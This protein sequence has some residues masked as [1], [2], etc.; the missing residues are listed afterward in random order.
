MKNFAEFHFW[1]NSLFFKVLRLF[2]FSAL[3]FITIY[4][5]FLK[6]YPNIF[7]TFFS[8]DLFV[9]IFFIYK[10]SRL[11][12]SNLVSENSSD[13]LD[14]FTLD[15]FGI[16][17]SQKTSEKIIK[18]LLN[19]P[20]SDFILG[21]AESSKK[22]IQLI[23]LDTKILA[24]NALSLAKELKGK[25]VTTM[26]LF[27]SYLLL[28]EEKTKFLFNKKLKQEDVKNILL[29][30]RDSFP[31]EESPK[32]QDVSFEG[33]GIAEEW[34]YGWTIETKKYM[35]DLSREFLKQRELPLGREKEYSELTEALSKGSSAILVG[36]AGSGKESAVRHLAIQSFMGKLPGNLFHQKIFQLMVDAFMAG[37]Q[38][39][40]ELQERLN[41]IIEEVS[42][43]GN[44][45]IYIPEFQNILGSSS[46][47]L[48][49]SGAIAP[50]VKRGSV[51]IVAAV[52]PGAYKKF[53]EPLHSL[54]D[55]FTVINFSEPSKTEV[56]DML[57]K[58][59]IEI[60]EKNSVLLS[61]KSVVA[62]ST[63]AD[64]YVKEKVLP[65]SAVT[66]LDDTSNAA[67][68]KGKKLVDE[69]DVLDQV[70]K[71]INVSVGEPK[72]LEKTLLL[73]MEKEFHKRII[74]QNEAVSSISESIRRLRA[75]LK[76]V[77]KP[78]SFLFLGPT[79]V[80]KT[81]TAKA[82]ADIYF[83]N[84]ERLVRLDMSEFSGDDGMRRLLGSGPG[85]GDEKG[86]LTEP[87]YDSPYSLI[88]LDEFEKADQKI[89][90][91]FLQVLDDGRLT[92]NKGKTVSFVNTIVIA[93]SN[94]ASEFIRE[95]IGKGVEVDKN[96]KSSLLGF[97]QEKGIFK[98]ELLNRFDDIVVFKP[99]GEEEVEQ[100]V[101]MIIQDVN[102]RLIEKD[103]KA[104][105]DESVF[106]KIA[107][108]GFDKDF[109]ARPLRRFVQ[110]N[111]EGAIAQK[112]LKDEI[113]RGDSISVL[114]DAS[115][116]IVIS[117][118]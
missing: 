105:F 69:Q 61:Y 2:I 115:N 59:S 34:I 80:G 95:E 65:G 50:Y 48:D 117:S 97:L 86:Q 77:N 91:L 16:F 24:E 23:S 27:V 108:E 30:A 29:W 118:K 99:L 63:Y 58:K 40:G 17:L 51:R 10:V 9:E 109:G 25:Y 101:K 98:P 102:K 88:L 75:G 44:V 47:N 55:G 57:F 42:H 39:Q 76:T 4:N 8:L 103:I 52:T 71:K 90:D 14:S 13:Y 28:T 12:P 62:A 87:V 94:A 83:G 81:E 33:E 64:R 46:F 60:E 73:N 72:Q 37:A 49:I 66:L 85:Q 116:N 112:M 5:I 36:D 70:E 84:S 107:L 11:L 19:L 43:T 74:D 56:L 93:T 26:D 35:I 104:T 78:I 6:V 22:D 114:V 32:S 113:K 53:V 67:R 110:D 92:D 100:I 21:K 7:I 1:Y 54:L 111:I 106:A 41:A 38:T 45:I 20:S 3:L 89:L 68:I 96:F 82:L 79:G 18:T 31:F 15:A